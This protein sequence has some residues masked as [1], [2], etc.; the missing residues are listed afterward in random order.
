ML[1]LLVLTTAKSSGSSPRDAAE[2]PFRPLGGGIRLGIPTNPI[3]WHRVARSRV[4]E[5]PGEPA[6]RHVTGLFVLLGCLLCVETSGQSPVRPPG[7]L[8][9]ITTPAGW[10]VAPQSVVDQMNA[11]RTAEDPDG[12]DYRYVMKFDP[13]D[14]LGIG[15]PYFAVEYTPYAEFAT[16]SWADIEEAF[17]PT[18]LDAA[19][20]SASPATVIRSLADQDHVLDR[21]RARWYYKYDTP[22]AAT[23]GRTLRTIGVGWFTNHG[24]LE[25]CLYDKAESNDRRLNDLDAFAASLTLDPGTGFVPGP[26]LPKAVAAPARS[27]PTFRFR[28]FGMFGFGGLGIGL[29]I[30]VFLV[31]R[32]LIIGPD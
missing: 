10:K 6:M 14:G 18:A 21:A 19:L 8:W 25:V 2:G 15:Y 32:R 1:S 23:S 20:A 11:Q 24:L 28:R 31:V 5:S 27:M 30:F 26:G 4:A 29:S 3:D 17:T 16:A 22:G 12:E 9:T 13:A 7:A